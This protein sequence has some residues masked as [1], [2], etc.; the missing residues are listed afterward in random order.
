MFIP[1][2][3]IAFSKS[4]GWTKGPERTGR[5]A[6]VINHGKL[7]YAEDEPGGEGTVYAER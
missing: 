2:A 1:D 5:Y 3:G 4:I 6:M 7:V